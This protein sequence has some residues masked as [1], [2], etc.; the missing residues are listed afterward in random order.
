M[1]MDGSSDGLISNALA[2]ED[3]QKLDEWRWWEGEVVEG[4]CLGLS[5]SLSS[6]QRLGGAGKDAHAIFVLEG[7]SALMIDGLHLRLGPESHFLCASS[8]APATLHVTVTARIL[9]LR[10]PAEVVHPLLAGASGTGRDSPFPLTGNALPIDLPLRRC[11]GEFLEPPVPA[12]LAG[13]YRQAKALETIVL[14]VYC[15]MRLAQVRVRHARTEYDRERI[16]YARDYLLANMALPP[17]IPELA[18]IAGINEF[19]LKKGFREL[20]GTTVF[21]LLGDERL[22]LAHAALTEGHKTVTEVAFEL[23]YSSLAHFSTR[24]KER[25]GVTPS[26][27]AKPR[28]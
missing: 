28:T 2:E 25:F 22:R 3:W 8:Q 18:A 13:S 16:R 12:S 24:F 14:Q 23:G 17:S 10:A 15:A 26:A 20:F 11:I 21:G 1:H 27:L 7:E 9:L 4:M 6:S 19:K 5:S